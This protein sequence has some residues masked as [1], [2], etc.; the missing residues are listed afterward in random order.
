[1]NKVRKQAW[2][3]TLVLWKKLSETPSV[4]LWSRREVNV[5]KNNILKEIGI[6]SKM[7]GCPFCEEYYGTSQCPLGDCEGI[8]LP[9][10]DTP[11]KEWE[12]HAHDQESAKKFYEY[13]ED[14]YKK[15]MR[16]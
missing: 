5:F 9:C 6:R 16:K 15:E 7:N 8:S 10:Y 1:M 11:Y 3:E 14:L 12:R 2:R 4:K 13:L